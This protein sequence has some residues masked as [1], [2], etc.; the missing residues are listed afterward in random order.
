MRRASRGAGLVVLGLAVVV[1]AGCASEKKM[2]KSGSGDIVADRQR[3][4]KLHGQIWADIQAKAKANNIE[5]IEVSAETLAINAQY[6]PAM[7]PEGSLTDKSKAKPEVWQKWPEFEAAAKKMETEAAKLRDAVQG[8][9]RPAHPGHRE[10]L[11]PERLRSLPH[12]VPRSAA[13]H[14]VAA[15][16][17]GRGRSTPPP[18]SPSPPRLTRFV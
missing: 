13:P 14:L 15:S 9:E 7:F 4:M 3:L 16:P 2:A 8:Q 1:A 10:G 17:S 18:G 11:R 12:A 6:I 5:G